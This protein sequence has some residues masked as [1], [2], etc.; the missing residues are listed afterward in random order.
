MMLDFDY[1]RRLFDTLPASTFKPNVGSDKSLRHRRPVRK[2]RSQRLTLRLRGVEQV[3]NGQ[4]KFRQELLRQNLA[5]CQ[6]GF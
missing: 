1:S 6:D 2:P 5:S 3:R 4:L